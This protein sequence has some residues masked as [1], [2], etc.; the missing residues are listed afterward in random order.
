MRDTRKDIVPVL[1]AILRQ[2]FFFTGTTAASK[3][4][5]SYWRKSMKPLFEWTDAWLLQAIIIADRG[6][7]ASYLDVVSTADSLNHDLL[8]T[9]EME[10]GLARLAEA[11]FVDA[12]NDRFFATGNARKIYAKADSGNVFEARDQLEKLIGAKEWKPGTPYPNPA[13]N[14]RFPAYS[15]EA[16][17]KANKEWQKQAR[18]IP[19]QEAD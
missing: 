5:F 10:S 16:H 2:A 6:N 3:E 4:G 1:V 7:G 14:R 15:Q 11:G 8:S 9:N 13:N 17:E 12:T 18:R 19:R